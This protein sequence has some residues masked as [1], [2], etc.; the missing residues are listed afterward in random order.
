MEKVTTSEILK[1]EGMRELEKPA[2]YVCVVD[3][4]VYFFSKEDIE[5]LSPK[6]AATLLLGLK[7]EGQKRIDA[8]N[9]TINKFVKKIRLINIV[10]VAGLIISLLSLIM[11]LWQV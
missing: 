9:E 7:I 5:K 4:C 11:R 10:C 1:Q 3:G 2:K 8:H 6:E